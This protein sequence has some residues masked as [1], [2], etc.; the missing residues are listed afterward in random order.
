ME[1]LWRWIVANPWTA[2]AYVYA[3]VNLVNGLLPPRAQG[4]VGKVL[5]LL[6]RL[7]LLRRG[8][9]SMPGLDGPSLMHKDGD[10]K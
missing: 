6:N 10:T 4:E 1:N 5:E 8:A 2:L 9:L 3:A 7:V